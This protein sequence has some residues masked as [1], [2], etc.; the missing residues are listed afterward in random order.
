MFEKLDLD[1]G[2]HLAFV[3]RAGVTP[4]V[5]FCGGFK[6]DMTGSK[7]LAL[8][9]L[10][11]A[12]RQAFTRFD[13]RGHGYSSGVFKDGTISAWLKDTLTI[14]D[15]VTAGPL[16][17]V[18]SSMG[19]WIAALAA[20]ARPE[21]VRGLVGI[22][23]A[24]DFTEDLIWGRAT[25][26]ERQMLRE[27]GFLERP[28]AY[29]EDPYLITRRLIEDGR[30]HLLLRGPIAIHCPVHLLHGQNDPDVPWQTTLR[31][32]ERLSTDDVNVELIK[33]GDHRLSTPLQIERIWAGIQRVRTM[34]GGKN[35]A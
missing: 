6:S 29:G 13:Y 21:R 18:G 35:A 28:S 20:L 23:A 14:V 12:R 4:G 2:G 30:E 17:L 24:P 9:A 11:A 15:R 27:T 26:A 33:A 7:V 8:E 5:M 10:C 3:H 25:A 31:F 32:A 34:I 19:A 1:G 16:I 22:A